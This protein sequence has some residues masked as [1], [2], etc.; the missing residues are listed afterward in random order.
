LAAAALARTATAARI[1]KDVFKV[2]LAK[3]KPR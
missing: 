3:G 2:S 1:D